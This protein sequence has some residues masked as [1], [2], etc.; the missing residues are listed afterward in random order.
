MALTA[1]VCAE[2]ESRKSTLRVKNLD[3][4]EW[5]N[6]TIEVEK[7]GNTYRLD[8]DRIPPEAQQPAEPFTDAQEF[9]YLALASGT[10]I[11]VGLSRETEQGLK[12]L[13]N[14]TGLDSATIRI[15]SPQPGEWK[16]QVSQCS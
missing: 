12:R 11:G 14:F 2:G 6:V 9:S 16:G 7:Q 8:S 10:G 3:D 13:H 5:R 1:E 4:F 15:T